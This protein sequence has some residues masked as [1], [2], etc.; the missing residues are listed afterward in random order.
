MR[1][2]FQVMASVMAV[3]LAS[4]VA[5]QDA[6]PPTVAAAADSV[7]EIRLKDGSVLVGRVERSDENTV[8]LV[9]VGGARTEIP[10]AQIVTMR[11]VL[12]RPDGEVWPADD[13]VSR[14]FFTSTGRSVPRGEGYVSAY[15]LFFP[16]VGYGV[17]DRF[18][19]A[20]GTPV[21]PGGI[22]EIV[23]LAPKYKVWD[24]PK[25]DVSVGALSFWYLPEADAGNVGILYGVG[26]YGTNDNALTFG[27]GWFYANVK[28]DFETSNEPVFMLGGER[29]VSRRL[30]LIT[31]NWFA[32]NPGVS[33]LMSGGFRFVGDRLSADFALAGLTGVEAACCLPMV[34]FVWSFGRQR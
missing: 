18:T 32:V 1:R 34:N 30:K 8:V 11:Q 20:G 29:R 10:R 17:T 5:A 31:E 21:V 13:N 7:T 19:I 9:T 15:W 4:P 25:L 24:A 16:F 23:Y 12:L 2:L 28:D 26:T 22:G 33:G 3:A 27:A 6:A 14:L